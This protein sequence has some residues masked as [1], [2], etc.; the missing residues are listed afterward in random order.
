[1][2]LLLRKKRVGEP[3]RDS[4]IDFTACTFCP[5]DKLK[6]ALRRSCLRTK[7]YISLAEPRKFPLCFVIFIVLPFL[8]LFSQA[9][10]SSFI[11]KIQFSATLLCREGF[12]VFLF[13]S[14]WLFQLFGFPLCI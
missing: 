2:K 7:V 5:V 1:M 12:E 4:C 10:S 8:C 3:E 13:G 14:K 9:I 6:N 11:R